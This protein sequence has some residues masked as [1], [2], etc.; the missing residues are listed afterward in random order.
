MNTDRAPSNRGG[1]G[2][3]RRG[4]GRGRGGRRGDNNNS[5]QQQG[6]GRRSASRGG[7][8]NSNNNNNSDGGR[9]RF[10]GRRT[11]ADADAA[12]RLRPQQPSLKNG[13]KGADAFTVSEAT[14]IGFTKRLM[15][16]RESDDNTSLEFPS[17]LTNTERKFLHQLASNL[18]LKSKSTGKAENRHI[19]VTKR[20]NEQSSVVD[21]MPQLVIG[22]EGVQALRNHVK[23]H[24]PTH[25][26]EL[27]SRETGASLLEALQST[28]D[29]DD[30]DRLA[31]A[32][33]QMHVSGGN[34]AGPFHFKKKH[35]NLDRRRSFHANAQELKRR[36]PNYAKMMQQ[37]EKL[38]AFKHEQEIV[39][40]IATH[41]ITIVSGETGS[42]KSTQTPQ[43]LLDALRK[44]R[45]TPS[46]STRTS[47]RFVSFL[48]FDCL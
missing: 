46:R 8:R 34:L 30:D 39:H 43:F 17:T 15:D 48:T 27:E 44:C 9:G 22:K 41:R 32:L 25:A 28:G 36:H 40:A 33:E 19:N 12:P 20:N 6:G 31:S 35:V 38:P 4:G 45:R 2:R 24:P 7:G 10:G 42:G 5:D 11:P 21:K 29:G 1:R 47:I 26:E 37:R 14:R 13:D 18:G 23:L 16:F 3:G